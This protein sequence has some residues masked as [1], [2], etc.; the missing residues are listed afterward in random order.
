MKNYLASI[1]VLVTCFS[2]ISYAGVA[3]KAAAK[4]LQTQQAQRAAVAAAE[5]QR[6]AQAV[7]AERA[8]KM[9]ATQQNTA[10]LAAAEQ[11]VKSF[12]PGALKT[13]RQA[14]RIANDVHK[15]SAD[16]TISNYTTQREI[17]LHKSKIGGKVG[18]M[19]AYVDLK[20][21]GYKVQSQVTAHAGGK[22]RYIDHVAQHPTSGKIMAFEIKTGAA[23]YPVKQQRFD[24]T[25]TSEGAILRGNNAKA[26]A[27][28]NI[29][30]PTTVP[31]Y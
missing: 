25:M 22:W 2:Q 21:A 23:R 9:Y 28:M 5:L 14:P 24:A 27:G 12:A 17:N 13:P 20:A 11:K 16:G 18:E 26:L 30:M 31:R 15:R 19:R 6:T 10:R 8:R 3:D 29:K 7:Q 4:L 1:A